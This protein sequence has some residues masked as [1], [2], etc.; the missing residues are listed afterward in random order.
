MIVPDTV[1][2]S[3]LDPFRAMGIDIVMAAM[4]G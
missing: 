3:D 4:N 2:A 1:P